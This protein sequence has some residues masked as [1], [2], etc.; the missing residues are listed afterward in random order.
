M[1]F[2]MA[3]VHALT[4]TFREKLDR[5]PAVG[6]TQSPTPFV[7]LAALTNALGGP[8]IWIKRDDAT[9]I[10]CGGNKLR[11]LDRV[12]G[13][14]LAEGCDTLVSG[15]VAQSNSQRQVAT[16]AAMLGLGCHLVVYEG[17][18]APPSEAYNISGNVVLNKL[19]GATMHSVTW[20][21]DR[22]AAIEALATKLRAQ[23]KTPFVVPYGVSNAMGALSYASVVLEIAKQSAELEF[24]PTAIFAAS[25]SGG[26]QAGLVIGAQEC[27]PDTDIIGIDVDAEPQRVRD[28]VLKYATEGAALINASFD[29]SRIELVSGFAGPAYGVPHVATLEAIRLIASLEAIILD[30]VYSGK[31]LAGLIGLIREGRFKAT[32]KVVLVH[33][34]GMPAVFAYADVF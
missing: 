19:L 5:F 21:G 1:V 16:A 25:G 10:S 6:L 29:P 27:L 13:Q 12:L 23:G 2:M 20:Q 17:R 4:D 28:D 11:K 24:S 9:H 33:T 14:A 30:P 7:K 32:D 34:G 18:V 3:T 8:E 31:A 26:T 22:N 15:G